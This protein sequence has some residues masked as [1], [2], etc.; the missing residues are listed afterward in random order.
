MKIRSYTSN[1][2]GK[3]V[4]LI[5]LFRITLSELKS[6]TRNVDLEAAKEELYGYLEQ[7]YPI[8]VAEIG[9]RV[10]GYLVCKVIDDTVWAESLYVS[11]EFRRK[12][13]GSALYQKAEKL[14]AELGA[15]TVYNWVHPNNHGIIA[16]LSERGYDVLNLIELR[17][18]RDS[19]E[20]IQNM[21]VCDHEYRF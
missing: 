11:P 7:D 1:D 12:G 10:V 4:E 14:A 20:L 19:E 17:K 2:E 6:V 8:Y 3:V 15:E 13:V 5:S 16:F 9:D 21:M 18:K